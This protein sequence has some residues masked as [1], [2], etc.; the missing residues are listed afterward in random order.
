MICPNCNKENKNTN[1]KCEFCFTQLIDEKKYDQESVILNNTIGKK[2]EVEVSMKKINLISNI[3]ILVI[4]G[5]W[6]LFGIIFFAIGLSLNISE[7]KQTKG[8][9][10]TTAVLKDYVNCDYEDGGDSCYAIY[11]YKVNGITYT[12]S[13][14][15]L[16]N[17]GAFDKKDTVY[18]N[19]NNPSESIMNSISGPIMITGL[20]IIISVVIVFV[21]KKIIINKISKKKESITMTVYTKNYLQ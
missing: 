1:I 8:Y 2:S 18:Y 14:K 7:H 12:V 16:G 10:K 17:A 13:P 5:P 4:A 15:Y 21:I 19:P 11:E 9:E 3:I 6:L 20:I